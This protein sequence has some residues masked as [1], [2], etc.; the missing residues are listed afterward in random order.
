MSESGSFAPTALP[1][2]HEFNVPVTQEVWAAM[3]ESQRARIVAELARFDPLG[4]VVWRAPP[5]THEFVIAHEC[6]DQGYCMM[7]AICECRRNLYETGNH[8]EPC[9]H[10]PHRIFQTRP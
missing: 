6:Y 4:Q 2:S 9:S 10:A 1:P 7:F 3:P 8:E 5:E